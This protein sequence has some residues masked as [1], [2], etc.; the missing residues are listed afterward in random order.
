MINKTETMFVIWHR[1]R[2][3][4]MFFVSPAPLVI[5]HRLSSIVP[6]SSTIKSYDTQKYRA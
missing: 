4:K 3:L 2:I 6:L 1:I 5:G